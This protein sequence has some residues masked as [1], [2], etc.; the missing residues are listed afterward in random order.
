M[1]IVGKQAV[2]TSRFAKSYEN[3]PL[4]EYAAAYLDKVKYILRESQI[5]LF[6]EPAKSMM[7]EDATDALEEFFVE[8]SCDRAALTE[9]QY[10]E[11][12]EDMKQLF[13][14]DRNAILEYAAMSSF[15]PILGLTYPIHK[16]IMMN[17]IF[18]SGVITKMVTAS[19]RFTISME[20]RTLVTP[21]GREIDMWKEQHLMT[22]AIEATAPMKYV[23]VGLPEIEYTDILKDVF[24]ATNQ[25]DNLGI[26]THISHI[27]VKSVLKK[28]ETKVTYTPAVIND[29]V[30]QTTAKFEEEEVQEDGSTPEYT[31]KE[32][33]AYFA[34]YYGE[35]D[36]TITQPIRATVV[37]KIGSDGEPDETTLVEDV[38]SGYMKKNKFM[39]Q[40][41]GNVAAVKIATRIDTSTALLKTCSVKWSVKTDPVEIPN[42]LP[43]N[44]A[45]SPEETQDVGAL[46]NVNQLTKI[47]SM[48]KAVM[49]NRKDDNIKRE[50]DKS[51]N[52]MPDTDKISR[53]FDFVPRKGYALDHITWRHATFMDALDS[54][55]SV[56][57][58]VLRD[59][60][61]VITVIG[62]ADIIRKLTP[63]EAEYSYQSP[64]NIGPIELD[65]VK[66]VVT[67]SNRVYQF[68]SS[69][70]MIGNNNLIILLNPRNT[71]RIIYRIYDYQTYVSNEIRNAELYTLPS[72]HAF[73][74]WKFVEYQPVQGRVQIL[75]PSGI[76]DH[77]PNLDPI[78][79]KYSRT[80]ADVTP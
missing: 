51:F 63:A 21:D 42:A 68:V 36:R 45:I 38:I 74:R 37:T 20:T 1:A 29:G 23:P 31:W 62:R 71:D 78:G 55:V 12:V 44:V 32:V 27:L 73:E 33:Y 34:P 72:I 30:V 35:Y 15:N 6:S 8:D 79:P 48:I 5:D 56:L 4:H 16:N 11:H 65:Y 77:T 60:N 10:A 2:D 76:I 17:N 67:K 47:M 24:H 50:L 70:K 49:G 53:T 59:P 80:D 13:K 69:D 58:Q 46:Y 43:F 39:L 57:L 18:D 3:D 54:Y 22:D 52:R 40:T 19:P 41:R 66:H 28:G 61:M 9:A 26:E 64:S 7:L 25:F 75:N 14:N